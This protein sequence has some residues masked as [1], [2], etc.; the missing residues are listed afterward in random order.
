[1]YHQVWK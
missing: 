1:M